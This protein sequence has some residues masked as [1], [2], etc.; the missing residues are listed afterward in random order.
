MIPNFP[1]HSKFHHVTNPLSFYT[2]CRCATC[3]EEGSDVTSS[4]S[5]LQ[6]FS[7]YAHSASS[8]AQEQYSSEDDN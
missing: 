5:D 8:E 4:D 2:S 3:L 7:D 1:S 6:H